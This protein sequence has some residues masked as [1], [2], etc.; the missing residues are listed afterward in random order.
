MIMT[1][2]RSLRWF[3]KQILYLKKM[4]YNNFEP[5]FLQL[6]EQVYERL[7]V[8][9]QSMRVPAIADTLFNPNKKFSLQAQYVA[10]N[11]ADE[12]AILDRNYRIVTK[13]VRFQN[14]SNVS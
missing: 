9:L 11:P 13:V 10:T 12:F 1:S 6:L 4:K 3:A 5:L 8:P 14:E 7:R 2:S